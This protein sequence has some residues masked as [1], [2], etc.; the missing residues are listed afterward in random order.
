MRSDKHLKRPQ[1][2]FNGNQYH[3]F[4]D[5]SLEQVFPHFALELWTGPSC[6]PKYDRDLVLFNLVTTYGLQ[7]EFIPNAVETRPTILIRRSILHIQLPCQVHSLLSFYR[8]ILS[9]WCSVNSSLQSIQS[10]CDFIRYKSKKNML[11]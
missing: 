4:I 1:D 9:A 11:H 10:Y 7:L 6:F 3:N 2:I 5:L 8:L